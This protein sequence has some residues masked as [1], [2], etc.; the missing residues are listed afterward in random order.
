MKSFTHILLVA[1]MLGPC[2]AAFAATPLSGTVGSNLTAYNPN[3]GAMNN[4]EWNAM[5]N[6]RSGGGTAATADFGNCNSVILRCASPK[7]ANG[8]CTSIDVAAPI[9]AGCVA[10]N[11]ACKQYGDELTQYIA[12]QLVANSNA[13]ANAQMAAAQNAAAEQS[14]MQMQQMQA[15]MQQMQA[16]MA[17][18]NAQQ[19]AQL[20][21]ALEEQQRATEAARAE[22]AAAA[23]A[24]SAAATTPAGATVSAGTMSD[25]GSVAGSGATPTTVM[26]G[27]SEAQRIA[28]NAGVSADILAREQVAGQILTYLEDAQKNLKT[29]NVAMQNAFEYAGC[30]R[31]GDNCVGPKRV[32]V[33]RQKAMDFFEP[34]DA[35]LDNL[36]DALILAQSVGVDITDIY[37]M[38]NGSCNVWGEYLCYGGTVTSQ[39]NTLNDKGES[40]PKFVSSWATYRDKDS[41]DAYGNPL[42]KNCI[43]GKSTKSAVTK[44]GIECQVGAVIPPEDSPACTLNRTLTDMEEVQRNFLFA[45]TG[46]VDEHVRIG[47][48][49]SALESSKFFRNRK[50]G[51]T[52]DIETL[53]RIISQDAPAMFGSNAFGATTNPKVDGPKYCA[54]NSTSYMELQKAAALKKLPSRVCVSDKSL[55][56]TFSTKGAVSAADYDM[57][58][59]HY[60]EVEKK[61]EVDSYNPTYS[62]KEECESHF[63]TP[64]IENG[65]YTGCDCTGTKRWMNGNCAPL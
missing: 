11:A 54:V 39:V 36:Y 10:S 56:A 53:E 15:Q 48:A 50:K 9:V 23:S 27:L 14:A 13:A 28:A 61:G 46:D 65:A 4:N 5:M 19:I 57:A 63:G 42:E 2:G 22:A 43:G 17:A 30:T 35:V 62:T 12:A 21:S 18:Q 51:S 29:A 8:G 38:L 34:Y 44:G 7:C 52:I 1:L 45:D 64:K 20:Q 58:E 47:C 31:S 25:G 16:D 6:S 26:E 32:S 24:A 3:G 59:K 60:A 49:S 40:V 37:M 33:F 41:K 55:A